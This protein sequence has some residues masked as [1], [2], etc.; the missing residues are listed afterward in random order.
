MDD[1][2]DDYINMFQAADWYGQIGFLRHLNY[3]LESFIINKD[4]RDLYHQKVSSTNYPEFDITERWLL[5]DDLEEIRFFFDRQTIVLLNTYLELMLKEFFKSFFCEH[6]SHMY[7]YIQAEFSIGQS[8][9]GFVSLKKIIETKSKQEL[10]SKLA[11][12]A[13]SNVMA[14]KFSSILGILEKLTKE[15]I[16]EEIRDGLL[17]I[18]EKRN[19]I[20]H[21]HNQEKLEKSFI[22]KAISD[23]DKFI[24]FLI[25]VAKKNNIDVNLSDEL[26]PS[27]N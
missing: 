21:E 7:D 11:D 25:K 14:Y 4:L 19:Q 13:T 9:K 2:S 8:Q 3:L 5:D 18:V 27:D 12:E 1:D 22:E 16:H 26:M 15:K 23:Y 24:V 20:V 17:K 6:H 10:I